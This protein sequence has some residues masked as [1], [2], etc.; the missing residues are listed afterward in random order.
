VTHE[1]YLKASRD[2]WRADAERL[3]EALEAL[4]SVCKEIQHYGPADAPWS[5]Q[6]DIALRD[7]A[8]LDRVEG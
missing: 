1:E 2:K 6:L 7:Y 4:A 3:R 8:A 5:E